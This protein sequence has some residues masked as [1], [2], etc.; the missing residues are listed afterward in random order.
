MDRLEVKP[1]P[2]KA[3]RIR[4]PGATGNLGSAFDAAGIA[5]QLYLTAEVVR[6]ERGPSRL[7]IRGQDAHLIPSDESNLT[8]TAM[9]ETA[10][11]A[12][13]KLPPFLLRFDN[14][15][16]VAR[17]LGSS[18]TACLA[19]AAAA[20]FLC[21]LDLG[22]E[23]WLRIATEMEGQP[24][25][26]A[27]SLMGGYVVTITGRKIFCS[28]ALL[29]A[30]WRI[31]AVIPEFELETKR[32]REVLP[33]QVALRDAVFNVQR[34][35]FL[36]AQIVQG[37]REGV[38][39]AMRDLLHQP[40]RARLVP[41]LEELLIMQDREGLIGIAL[42]GAG[43]TVIALVDGR[44]EEI[45]AAMCDVFRRHGLEATARLLKPDNDGLV[46]RVEDFRHPA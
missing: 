27:P 21:G 9:R 32:A 33:E 43:P 41:G 11:R 44:G 45:G 1:L 31:V 8:W 24:D 29:P 35:S 34:A 16:P 7:E 13:A 2:A 40:Y 38:R 15:I 37:R 17:G 39:E 20:D 22:R 19:G 18:S 26:V 5:V 3:A 42:S 46:M 36:A 6:L 10:A 28:R 4:I 25:N 12:K 14:E 30:D 23:Q